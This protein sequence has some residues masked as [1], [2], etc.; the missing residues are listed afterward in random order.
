MREE[1]NW[2]GKF[3]AGDRLLA[4]DRFK[5]KG[6]TG[7]VPIALFSKSRNESSASSALVDLMGLVVVAR[8]VGVDSDT[9]PSGD[10]V[11]RGP[12]VQVHNGV[13]VVVSR[14]VAWENSS[15]PKASWKS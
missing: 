3:S 2:H 14:K 11:T 5:A 13:W 12:V 6:L 10:H 7:G 8:A 4:I 1:V 9:P 15:C